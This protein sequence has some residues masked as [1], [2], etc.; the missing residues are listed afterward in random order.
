MGEVSPSLRTAHTHTPF[1]AAPTVL[2]TVIQKSNVVA[3]WHC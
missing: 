1:S 2:T 3:L